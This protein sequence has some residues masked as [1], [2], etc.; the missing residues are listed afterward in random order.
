MPSLSKVYL[1][2]LDELTPQ[3]RSQIKSLSRQQRKI[4]GFLSNQQGAIS[5]TEIA[6]KN[7][8]SHQT[9]SSQLKTLLDKKFVVKHP[10]GRESYYELADFQL[11]HWMQSRSIHGAKKIVQWVDFVE[12]SQSEG[13]SIMSKKPRI[14]FV[15]PYN[16]LSDKELIVWFLN[17]V[18]NFNPKNLKTAEDKKLNKMFDHYFLVSQLKL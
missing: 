4:V 5:V 11:R 15:K 16:K 9:A 18:K 3:F 10:F 8:L 12:Q 14:D 13:I 1:L 6:K 2:T 17:K 7:F